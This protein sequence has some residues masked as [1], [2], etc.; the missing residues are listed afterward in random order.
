MQNNKR[1]WLRGAIIGALYF[2]VIFLCA[3]LFIH[4]GE[5]RGWF[6][7][8]ANFPAVLISQFFDLFLNI[9]GW[10]DHYHNSTYYH[11]LEYS[12]IGLMNILLFM[13]FGWIY[14]KIKNRNR[15]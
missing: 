5:S 14:G 4:S 10:I 2:L 11:L 6:I 9:N 12:Y 1:Y 8:I 7:F 15:V 3:N 13:F